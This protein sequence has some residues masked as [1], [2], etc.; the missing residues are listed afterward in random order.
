VERRVTTDQT[1][2][3]TLQHT[4][5]AVTHLVAADSGEGEA[6]RWR[7]VTKSLIFAD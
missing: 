5:T 1:L 7:S 6:E 2:T 4:H 3:H